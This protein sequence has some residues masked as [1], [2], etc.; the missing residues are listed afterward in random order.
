MT[1]RRKRVQEEEGIDRLASRCAASLEAL[2]LT[3]ASSRTP[4]DFTCCIRYV[5]RMLAALIAAERMP[6]DRP[7]SR[8]L[9]D[10]ATAL[11]LTS[12][13]TTDE[14]H[15]AYERSLREAYDRTGVCIFA[16]DDFNIT[17]DAFRAA[18]SEFMRPGDA[19]IGSLFFETMPL[20]WLGGAYEH[21]LALKPSASGNGL[22]ISRSRRKSV[23]LYF[24]PASLVEYI[25]SSVIKPQM[26]S[27]LA[28]LDNSPPEARLLSLKVLDP[29]MGGGD[30]LCG[31][32]ECLCENKVD[33]RLRAEIA[34]ECVY[35]VDIDPIAVDISRFCVWAA[36]GFANGIMDR[37]N[38]HLVCADALS[39][40]D[41]DAWRQAFP[42][43]FDRDKPGF[44]AVVGNPPYIA[45]KNGL[46]ATSRG[47]S[48]T[49]LLFLSTVLDR[50][51]VRHGGML[52]MV[53]PDP[54]L[55]RAN[56]A[57]IRRRLVSDWTV[58]SIL[59]ISG[60]FPDAMVAN[61]VPV[62]INV[63]ASAA[64]NRSNNRT[65]QAT[66]IERAA[67]R[68]DFALRPEQTACELAHPVRRDAV[69]A[70][71]GCEFLYLLEDG[72][73][74]DIIRR[75]HGEDACL[76]TYQPPFAPLEKLNISVIYRGEE[77]GK[78]AITHESGD[79]PMLL[80]GQS[81]RPYEIRWEGRMVK[82]SAIR[83]PVLRYLSTKIVVQKSSPRLVAALDRVTDDHRGYVFPQSV[84]GIELR[85]SG[86]HEVYLL[87]LLNSEVMNEYIRRT[88]TGYKLVQPQIE[89]E[90]IR[91]LPIREIEF[92]ADPAD[93][94]AEL[95][96]GIDLYEAES[97]R[98][99]QSLPF[100][101]LG[102]FVSEC[103]AASPERSDVVHDLLVH[104]GNELLDHI[105]A[106]KVSPSADNTSRLRASRA[107]IESIVWRLYSSDPAQ[108]S[109]PF[110]G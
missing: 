110:R 74:G 23:G 77:I 62:C 66:R 101:E 50:D 56:G 68:R 18:A 109:L 98:A 96:H 13:D 26:R 35:G 64:C 79:L 29:S 31:A 48:D 25:T 104:I 107:A 87:C 63:D 9:R 82:L 105:R 86:M 21:M 39:D 97:P 10:A 11:S 99:E 8:F 45:S 40:I 75:I 41:P 22:E 37:I 78:A 6:S 65:F 81:I 94:R 61:V 28:K 20:F 58:E 54:M 32:I 4:P 3:V 106:D 19:P 83:K 72:P 24:T 71:A 14:P 15:H 102:N 73:F 85:D 47:Q 70:Q 53:L 27:I 100:S 69:L 108:M 38:A 16:R 57:D 49:Y 55:V 103:L 43:A 80:G 36:S 52:S 34:A 67:D 59:H 33:G 88:V 51:L 42:Q 91:A 84:Y 12:D 17:H 90:D 2:Y 89:I 5:T 92:A 76:S 60:A 44:D 7:A 93:R 95:R 1:I 30:F 46:T